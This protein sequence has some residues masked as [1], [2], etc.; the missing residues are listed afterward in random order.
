MTTTK[1]ALK[2]FLM[3]LPAEASFS[4]ICYAKKYQWLGGQKKAFKKNDNNLKT[5]I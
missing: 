3:S 1:K 4:I 5:A 2:L